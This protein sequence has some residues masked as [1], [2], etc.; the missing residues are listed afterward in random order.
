MKEVHLFCHCGAHLE[1][2]G[3]TDHIELLLP[4]SL[5]CNI[6]GMAGAGGYM[7]VECV[8][9]CIPLKSLHCSESSPALLKLCKRKGSFHFL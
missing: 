6:E 9:V 7:H 4:H 2:G 3:Y 5:S 8:C 1:G